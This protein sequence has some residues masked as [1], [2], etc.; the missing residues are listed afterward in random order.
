MS[1]SFGY[2][3]WLLLASVLIAG[4]LTYWTYRSTIPALSAG[5]KWGL[6]TLRFLALTLLCFLLLEPVVRHVERIEQPPVLAV[7]IDDSQSL[8]VTTRSPAASGPGD[9]DTTYAAPRRAVRE[10]LQALDTGAASVRPFLFGRQTRTFPNAERAIP[11]GS[12][13]HAPT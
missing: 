6:G 4:G 5:W 1:F 12:T 10:A 9:A 8:R 11:S 13:T 2:S 7:L 3:P